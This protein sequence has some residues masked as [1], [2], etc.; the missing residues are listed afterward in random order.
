MRDAGLIL[1]NR[2]GRSVVHTLTPIGS[3]VLN[4]S[5]DPIGSGSGQ[6]LRSR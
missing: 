4:A 2:V 3:A 1:T 6:L 5:G